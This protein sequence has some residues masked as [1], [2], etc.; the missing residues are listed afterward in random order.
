M[1]PDVPWQD[2]QRHGK[3]WV[4]D[5]NVVLVAEDMGFR[6]HR[7][8]LAGHS[9]VFR[10]MFSVPQ[11]DTATQQL[12]DGCTVVRIPDEAPEPLAFVL[13]VIY[14]DDESAKYVLSFESAAMNF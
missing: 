5:G 10:D 14:F 3:L 2:V 9:E 11:P 8:V 7:G 12:I 6:V 4:D 13:N 1:Q